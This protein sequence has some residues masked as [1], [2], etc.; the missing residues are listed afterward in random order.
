M[1]PRGLSLFYFIFPYLE[2][3]SSILS[4]SFFFPCPTSLIYDI[5]FLFFQLKALGAE[6]MIRELIQYLD[7]AENIF[8]R[9][10]IY[11]GT[12]IYNTVLHSLVEAKEVGVFFTIGFPFICNFM[13]CGI[14][15]QCSSTFLFL[16]ITCR[17]KWQ[18]R[19]LK[20]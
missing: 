10:N 8:C 11:L 4:F 18:L 16:M 2:P 20:I 5:Q 1:P 15:D 6:G 19:Y 7:V 13:I 14:L 3:Y 12:P 17:V 9:N